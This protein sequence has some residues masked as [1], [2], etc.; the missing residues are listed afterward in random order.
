MPKRKMPRANS[1]RAKKMG[2]GSA[3]VEDAAYGAG[4]N[5]DTTHAPSQNAVYDKIN[6]MISDTAYNATS[7]NGVTTIAPSKNAV[8]DKIESLAGGG[9]NLDGGA[10]DSSYAAVGAIDGGDATS[11]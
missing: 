10:A 4:W 9:T 1:T 5:A 2:Q 6:A 7:W 11:F 8:R 3:L